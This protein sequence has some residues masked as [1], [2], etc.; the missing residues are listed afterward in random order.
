MTLNK[1]IEHGK[2]HRK[3]YRGGKAVDKRCRNHGGCDYCEGNRK[4]SRTKRELAAE[5]Y[6]EE[7]E[8]ELWDGRY[9]L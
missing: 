6:M 2:E 8:E 5:Q 7:Y 1:S 4:Y 9:R 3:E